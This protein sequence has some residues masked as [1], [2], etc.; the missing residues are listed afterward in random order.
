[1]A[2]RWLTVLPLLVLATGLA[3]CNDSSSSHAPMMPTSVSTVSLPSEIRRPQITGDVTDTAFRPLAG[4]R[5][6]IVGGP[7][8]GAWTTANAGGA[9]SFAAGI[10]DDTTQV[11]AVLSGYLTATRTVQRCRTCPDYY[12]HFS[13]AVPVPPVTLAGNYNLTFEADSACTDLPAEIRTRS[14]TASVTAANS[15][16]STPSDTLFSVILNG[17]SFIENFGSF[18]IGVA[19]GY[20]AFSLEDPGL[21]EHVG[22]NTYVAIGGVASAT[23]GAS[24]SRITVPFDGS[25]EYCERRPPI[26]PSYQY[27][28]CDSPLAHARCVSKNHRLTLIG[29]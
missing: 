17:A 29:H 25:I 15:D 2:D 1:M 8:G 9:F 18:W 14:Y 10:F 23:V 19:G 22:P 26:G 5:I 13:L 11:R 20:V 16:P 4:T 12:A 24:A 7:E 28:K 21:V 6:E 27:Y 3:G